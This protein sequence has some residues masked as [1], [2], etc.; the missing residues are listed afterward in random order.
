MKN[1]IIKQIFYILFFIGKKVI[2]DIF[3][4]VFFSSSFSDGQW[5]K[6]T[7]YYTKVYRHH[8]G[9]VFF[10]A[11]LDGKF[12]ETI[13][14]ALWL[15]NNRDEGF[16]FEI[17]IELWKKG[18]KYPRL[19]FTSWIN[20]NKDSADSDDGCKVERFHFKNQRFIRKLQSEFHE[21]TIY[22]NDKKIK[23]Y[24]DGILAGIFNNIHDGEMT[25]SA[26]NVNIKE[27]IA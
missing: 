9:R 25:I 11:K 12:E 19:V 26:G 7:W 20:N 24:I 8:Y 6:E 5:I 10:K 4:W 17:D 21:Y 27:I 22:R 16:Y 23:F 18:I 14:P 3:P 15:I 13:W 2:K 1:F